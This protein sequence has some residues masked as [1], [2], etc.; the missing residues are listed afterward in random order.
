MQIM[1]GSKSRF[2]FDNFKLVFNGL[3][4]ELWRILQEL[5]IVYLSERMHDIIGCAALQGQI[6]S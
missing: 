2:G 5:R 6:V 4:P 3:V 1:L